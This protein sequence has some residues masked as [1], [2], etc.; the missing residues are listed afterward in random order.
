MTDLLRKAPRQAAFLFALSATLFAAG[1]SW[2]GKDEKPPAPLPDYRASAPARIVW[3]QSI[4]SA[5]QPGF[6]PSVMDNAVYAATPDGTLA[7][8]DAATGRPNWR[9]KTGG[10]LTA[11]TGAE[12]G[13]VAVGT[14]KG[15]VLAFDT[16]GKSK[17]TSRVS[18]E[19]MG[20]P[21]I[22]E[23]IVAVWSGDGNVFGLSAADGTRRWVLQR[24]M[25]ALSVRNRAGG[26]IARGAVFLGVA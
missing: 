11:G 18:S 24:T 14:G 22:S 19:V 25:P 9:I 6:A 10:R 26:V 23:G 15:E 3:Q 21:R 7:S 17:W 8:F 12:G 20:P 13:V 2:F 1:C 5:A 4:E 16:A